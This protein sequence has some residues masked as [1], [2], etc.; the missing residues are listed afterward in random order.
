[1]GVVDSAVAVVAVPEAAMA[2]E[3]GSREAGAQMAAAV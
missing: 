2:E 1:M 3:V